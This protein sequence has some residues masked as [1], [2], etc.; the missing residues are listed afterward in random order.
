[1]AEENVPDA[2]LMDLLM[3]EM[4]GVES[5]SKIVKIS[6]TSRIIVLT[7]YTEDEHLFPA[8]RAGAHGYLLKDVEPAELVSAIRAA[9]RGQVTIHPT[10]A[11]KLIGGDS[12]S[13]IDSLSDLTKREIE[14]LHHIALG[15]RNREIAEELNLAECTVKSH[16]SNILSK[17]HFTHRTQ[18]AL[19]DLKK[20]ITF[21]DTDDNDKNTG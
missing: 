7:S 12:K 8:M 15:K 2:I 20:K 18:A 19:F 6:P 11:E 17:L 4:S 10:V 13:E 21:L 1:M 5:I 3:P 9:V 14:I 16:V